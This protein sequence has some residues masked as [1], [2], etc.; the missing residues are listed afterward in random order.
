MMPPELHSSTGEKVGQR[1]RCGRTAHWFVDVANGDSET[2]TR[3][4]QFTIDQSADAV[5]WVREDGSL[6]YFNETA[7]SMLGYSREEMAA[8]LVMDIDHD[9]PTAAWA[10]A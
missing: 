4:A 8:L 7:A 3:I 6:A 1:I 5:Y 2:H 10:T 9:Y